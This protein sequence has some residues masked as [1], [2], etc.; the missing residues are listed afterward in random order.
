[1]A[2]QLPDW[3]VSM[4]LDLGRAKLGAEAVMVGDALG[5][6]D[7]D[8][9]AFL[10]GDV[11]VALADAGFAEEARNRIETNLTRW[12]DDFWIRLHAGDALVVLGDLDGAEAHFDTALSMADEADDL[13]ARSY[14][15][16][17]LK[18]LGRRGLK[19]ERVKPA[20]RR[21][22]SR[23]RSRRKRKR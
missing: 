17:R 2:A 10:D 5:R 23:N 15:V 13:D 14:A 9:R 21:G 12:P 18:S 7:P 8:L 20:G 6:V 16:E 1:M 22:G 3:L 19:E 11:A 4:V